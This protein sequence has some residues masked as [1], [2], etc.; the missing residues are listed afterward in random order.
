MSHGNGGEREGRAELLSVP[1]LLLLFENHPHLRGEYVARI[2][3][4]LLESVLAN[5]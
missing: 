4:S 1:Q 2:P 3:E 5:A